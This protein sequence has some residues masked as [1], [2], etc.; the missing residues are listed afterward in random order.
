MARVSGGINKTK[1]V[2]IL[3]YIQQKISDKK[4]I[5]E[6]SGVI[7]TTIKLSELV[8]ALHLESKPR[9]CKMLRYLVEN[10]LL[11][12]TVL[13]T[14]RGSR[15]RKTQAYRLARHIENRDIDG[16][17][18]RELYPTHNYNTS[19]AIKIFNEETHNAAKH[20][21]RRTFTRLGYVLKHFFNWDLDRF[22]QWCRWIYRNGKKGTYQ[23]LRGT[24]AVSLFVKRRFQNIYNKYEPSFVEQVHYGSSKHYKSTWERYDG[25]K[26]N[27]DEFDRPDAA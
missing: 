24:K 1:R 6:D 14:Y 2:E 3:K 27:M 16:L 19:D 23:L 21:G 8:E 5:V 4:D 7:Y 11:Y 18:N 22:R 26:P 12:K 25:K 9:I 20:Y 13:C 17:S 15:C 10:R